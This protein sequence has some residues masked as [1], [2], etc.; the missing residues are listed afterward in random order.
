[1]KLSLRDR[2]LSRTAAS[3]LCASVALM[4]TNSAQA[5][6]PPA[7]TAAKA[8]AK[9]P[10]KLPGQL[11]DQALGS[12][13]KTMGLAPKK[14]GNRYDFNFKALYRGQEW[15]LSM[16]TVF[17]QNEHSIWVMAW[18]DELPRSAAEVPRTALLRLLTENDRMGRGKFFAY[19]AG[20]RRFVLQ[21]IVRNENVRP[22]EL[23]S[24]LQDL[25]RTVVETYPHW[26]VSQWQGKKPAT[27]TASGAPKKTAARNPRPRTARNIKQKYPTRR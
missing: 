3:V 11:S 18:L 26:S 21:K 12:M 25:G 9:A 13:L 1:M 14:S 16:S 20:N 4:G 22:S 17:S 27:Q 15:E 10:V 5:A 6:N 2:V 24:A 7:K 8:P 23:R 19:V